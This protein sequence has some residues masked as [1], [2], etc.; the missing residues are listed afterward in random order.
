MNRT[1][2]PAWLEGRMRIPA[3]LVLPIITLLWMTGS[4]H[5]QV[6]DALRSCQAD[7]TAADQKIV[8]CSSVITDA[9]PREPQALAGIYMSRGNAYLGKR[10]FD[11]AVADFDQAIKL[12]PGS[13]DGYFGRGLAFQ[14]QATTADDA[15]LNEGSFAARAVADMEGAR[16][17]PA[18]CRRRQQSRP[19]LSARAQ[20]RP[21]HRR[22]Q[23]GNTDQPEQPHL[24]D[25]PRLGLQGE[26]EKRPGDRGLP[27]GA[28]R[29]CRRRRAPE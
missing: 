7:N 27:Q 23:P 10:Q 14:G 25:Q 1:A 17:A 21:R 28:Q 8:A 22:L 16:A 19:N 24:Y 15:S 29:Q 18:K 3:S 20:I 11:Q 5:A 6:T 12:N 4:A 9:P 26:P 13:T 2:G